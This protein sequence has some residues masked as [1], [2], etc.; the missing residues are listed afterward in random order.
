MTEGVDRTGQPFGLQMQRQI[1]F[2]KMTDQD[3]N[4]IVAWVRTI[5]PLERAGAG[6]AAGVP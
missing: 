3:L 6:R 2:A 5:P 1:Y 4:A